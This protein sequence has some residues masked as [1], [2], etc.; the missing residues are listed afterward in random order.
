ML[1]QS[2]FDVIQVNFLWSAV[3]CKPK[4][5]LHTLEYCC[6]ISP[7]GGVQPHSI[8]YARPDFRKSWSWLHTFPRSE[9]N[10]PRTDKPSSDTGMDLWSNLAAYSWQ[11]VQIYQYTVDIIYLSVLHWWTP[12][13]GILPWILILPQV[14]MLI[15]EVFKYLIKWTALYIYILGCWVGTGAG[16]TTREWKRAKLSSFNSNLSSHAVNLR[17]R[18]QGIIR[19]S[20]ACSW[21]CISDFK[22][23]LW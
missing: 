20:E 17:K 1:R 13:L 3:C 19:Y 4:Y 9:E 18:S 23:S 8:H 21:S 11:S 12:L 10:P 22:I 16:S 5:N 2:P 14:L 15:F 7:P 6:H